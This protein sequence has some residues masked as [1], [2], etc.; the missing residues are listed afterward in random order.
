MRDRAVVFLAPALAGLAT[1]FTDLAFFLPARPADGVGLGLVARVP[2]LFFTRVTAFAVV[3]R[4]VDRF[5]AVDLRA[6]FEAA[7]LALEAAGLRAAFG[8]DL[9]LLAAGFFVR[10]AGFFTV[11]AR[12]AVGAAAAAASFAALRSRRPAAAALADR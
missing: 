5:T 10:S 3:E 12:F 7:A 1:A 6:T 2:L 11:R 4:G 9:A 8:A